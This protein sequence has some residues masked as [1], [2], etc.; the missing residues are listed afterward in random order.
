MQHVLIIG[1]TSGMAMEV[2]KLYAERKCRLFLVARNSEKL[3]AV[4]SD[5]KARGAESVAAQV[6]NL[7][8]TDKHPA[9]VAAARD[10]LGQLDVVLIAHGVF[11]EQAKCESDYR[12]TESVLRTNL[13]SPISL[14]THLANVMQAQGGGTLAVISSVAGDRGRQSNYVYGSS[15]AGLSAFLSGLRAR[16]APRGV[17]VITIKPGFVDTAMTAAIK[18][19][20]LFA[21]AANA[22]AGIV[23]AIDAR[24]SIAYVPWFWWGIM[25][26][27]KHIPE[28]IFKRLKF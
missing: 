26:I 13:L 10:F 12:L 1:A 21:S 23:R 28:V 4:E 7:D 9:L 15:K 24:R 2:A 3:A 6:V 22:A 16:L 14:C 20:P 11:P 19:G 8:E 17:N 18:K 25:L 5:L 27:I